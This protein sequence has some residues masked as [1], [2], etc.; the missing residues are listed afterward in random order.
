[1][2]YVEALKK[3]VETKKKLEEQ[4]IDVITQQVE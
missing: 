3:E 1:M 2:E 4:D